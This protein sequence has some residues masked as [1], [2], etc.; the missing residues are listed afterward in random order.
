MPELLGPR[1]QQEPRAH[2]ALLVQQVQRDQ[3]PR[4]LQE[5]PELQVPLVH[6]SPG[7]VHG[8][9]ALVMILMTVWR[10][11]GMVMSASSPIHLVLTR[12]SLA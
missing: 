1:V 9:P 7:K 12:T 10:T 4:E 6:D 11:T 2:R 5:L 8:H 3:A